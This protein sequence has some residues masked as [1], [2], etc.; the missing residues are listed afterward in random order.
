[1]KN[2]DLGINVHGGTEVQHI[3]ILADHKLRDYR[4]VEKRFA[5]I[6]PLR[7]PRWLLVLMVGFSC[8]CFCK[9]NNGG[10]DVALVSFC[11]STVAMYIRKVMTH[12]SM[13]PQIY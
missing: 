3:V 10:W 9:L 7:Y 6:V 12:R 4:E 2:V 1:R 13:H 5:Q 8:A 11:A